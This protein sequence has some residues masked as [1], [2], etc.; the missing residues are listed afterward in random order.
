[1]ARPLVNLMG[2]A[3]PLLNI[4][5]LGRVSP[6]K[7]GFTR[8]Q[9]EVIAR[10]VR[11]APEVMV[12]VTG[13]GTQPGAVA[14]HLSYVSR[15]GELD[16]ETDYGERLG[17]E[18]QKTFLNEWHLELSTGQY[19]GNRSGRR[20]GRR[21]KLVHNIVL[22]MPS[23]TSP[24]KVLAASRKFAQEKFGAKHRYALVLHTDQQH[25]HV[26]LVVKAEDNHGRRLHIDK[27]MLRAWR[28][29]FAE[30]MREQDVAAN[31]TPRVVRGRNKRSLKTAIFR[32]QRRGKSSAM[33]GRLSE[34]T[35]EFA[36]T[37]TIRDPAKLKL[38]ET[39]K[40]VLTDWE[41]TAKILDDQGEIELAGDVRYFAKKMRPVM[42]DKEDLGLQ[43]L[44]HLEANRMPGRKQAETH[45][46]H[47]QSQDLTR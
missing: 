26:H 13:G 33:R 39:R 29:D 17:R 15:K 32:A 12:K 1:M 16:I 21:T 5:S 28:E 2:D 6:L 35:K 46:A 30:M 43:F 42:T 19:R 36:E 4:R 25:P 41:K 27:E 34:I 38:L 14:A 24:E 18:E 7:G 23:P 22:S 8:A 44:R 10:T 47:E 45:A 11:R 31:A 37:G 9:I 20:N 40:S 3:K